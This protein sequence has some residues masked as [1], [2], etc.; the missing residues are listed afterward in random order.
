MKD[1]RHFPARYAAVLIALLAGASATAQAAPGLCTTITLADLASAFTDEFTGPDK[2]VVPA[3][4]YRGEFDSCY[5]SGAEV[6]VEIKKW[7]YDTEETRLRNV[8]FLQ[9]RYANGKAPVVEGLGDNAWFWFDTID[10]LK[11]SDRYIFAVYPTQPA[12]FL[13][14]RQAQ[15]AAFAKLILSRQ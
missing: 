14:D 11:G 6:T 3:T 7:H 12:R 8:T 10:V 13:V 1:M 15:I 9:T 4:A 2:L 5:Y